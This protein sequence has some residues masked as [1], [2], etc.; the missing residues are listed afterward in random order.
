MRQSYE[1]RADAP[2]LEEVSH[3]NAMRRI[4][5]SWLAMGFRRHKGRD[6]V[7]CGSLSRTRLDIRAGVRPRFSFRCL[8]NSCVAF[9]PAC[10][11]VQLHRVKLSFSLL[12]RTARA[13][14]QTVRQLAPAPSQ[15]STHSRRGETLLGLGHH[16]HFPVAMALQRRRETVSDIDTGAVDA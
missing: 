12:P 8:E 15:H 4:L 10:L 16:G 9:E 13:T 3:A 11:P 1:R 7:D 14:G 2:D 6:L 5:R